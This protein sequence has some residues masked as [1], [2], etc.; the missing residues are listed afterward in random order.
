MN[1]SLF[2]NSAACVLLTGLIF[3][4]KANLI[5]RGVEMTEI[6]IKDKKESKKT[7]V[8]DALKELIRSQ[9]Y[10]E[11][12]RLPSE[13]D[14]AA[15]LKVSRNVL[16]EAV[17]SLAAEGIFEIRERQGIFLKGFKSFGLVDALQNL[18]LLPADFVSYQL[19]VRMI[20]EVPAAGLAA[21]RRTEDDLRKL[22]ECFESFCAC[23]WGTHE[24]Q[25][26]NGRW[27]ALLH[28]LITEAAHNPLISRLNESINGLVERNNMLVHPDMLAEEGWLEHIRGQHREIISAIEK[29]DP[30]LAQV[31]L[32]K[33]FLDSATVMQR[34]HPE[35]ITEIRFPYWSISK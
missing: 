2:Y 4:S 6:F 13:R 24:E 30:S 16:R 7:I 28:H 15:Y 19:E 29:Q 12:D 5:Y 33:H 8:K 27:E 9:N 14:L 25:V 3:Q 11:G 31:M 21:M 22:R 23:P 35:L 18:Q 17:I 10:S 1:K 26:Q 20:I 32:K 34:N